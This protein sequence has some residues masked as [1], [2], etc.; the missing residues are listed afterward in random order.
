M[1]INR[2]YFGNGCSKLRLNIFTDASEEAKSIMA[3]LQD[4]ETL[5]LIYVI[6]K[7][8][9]NPIRHTTIPKL[10]LQAEFYGVCLTKHILREHDITINK[11]YHWTDSC[12]VLQCYSQLSRDNNCLLPSGQQKTGKCIENPADIGIREM[13]NG[14]KKAGWFKPAGIAADR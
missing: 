4:E 7:C 5:K 3:Y 9:V 13:S 2:F 1:L 12:T 10:A 6:R 8:L 11:F 14:F